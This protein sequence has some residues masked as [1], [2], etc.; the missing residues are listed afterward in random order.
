MGG[1]R[2]RG[3][4][5][6][7]ARTPTPGGT[8]RAGRHCLLHSLMADLVMQYRGCSIQVKRPAIYLDQN[9]YFTVKYLR[10][11]EVIVTRHPRSAGDGRC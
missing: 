6:C 3:S 5:S 11:S 9:I 7:F 2:M 1:R 8:R 4:L 10:S